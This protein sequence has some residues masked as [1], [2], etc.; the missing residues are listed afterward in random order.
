[1]PYSQVQSEGQTL[2][3]EEDMSTLQA[4]ADIAYWVFENFGVAVPVLLDYANNLI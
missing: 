3:G 1:M 4:L 2:A